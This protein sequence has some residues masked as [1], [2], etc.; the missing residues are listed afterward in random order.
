[1]LQTQCFA[2]WK[3]PAPKQV[4]HYVLIWSQAGSYTRAEDIK[5]LCQISQGMASS[6]V[7][8]TISAHVL[9]S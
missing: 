5:V 7:A 4:G 8:R 2:V 3:F 9:I 1:M 6:P